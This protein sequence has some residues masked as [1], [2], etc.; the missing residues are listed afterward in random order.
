MNH[1]Y[2]SVFP[3]FK[4]L[5]ALQIKSQDSKCTYYLTYCAGCW[6]PFRHRRHQP[7]FSHILRHARRIID[8]LSPLTV[9][10]PVTQSSCI[11]SL[12]AEKE[13]TYS[14]HASVIWY[15]RK[16]ERYRTAAIHHTEEGD[17]PNE[18]CNCLCTLRWKTKI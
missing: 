17:T 5:F 15:R 6:H 3:Y 18:Q 14:H 16:N 12:V 13:Q 7:S 10:E 2:R 8:A 4:I 9:V 1:G 11:R